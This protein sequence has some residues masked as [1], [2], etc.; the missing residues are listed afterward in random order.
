MRSQIAQGIYSGTL[1]GVTSLAGHLG[2]NHKTV[3]SALEQLEAEGVLLSQGPRRGRLIAPGLKAGPRPMRIVVLT[4]EASDR[5]E[6]YLVRVQ[7]ALIEAGHEVTFARKSITEL[8]MNVVSLARMVKGSDADVWVVFSGSF[9]VLEWFSNRGIPV[10]AIFGRRKSFPIAGMSVN[11]EGAFKE[12]TEGLISRGHRRMVM[13]C[14]SDRRIPKIGTFER[15]FLDTLTSHEIPVGDYNLPDWEESAAGFRELLDSLFLVTPPTVLIFQESR[16]LLPAMQFLNSKGLKV[17]GNVSL[18]CCASSP[19]FLW[20]QP[21][22][23]H[24]DWEFSH[25]IRRVVRWAKKISHGHTDTICSEIPAHIV[26][27]QSIGPVP[28]DIY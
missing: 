19:D 13:I 7:H 20:C 26:D 5:E 24:L 25:L 3:V 12:V 15:G 1:P 4:Y 22:I 10:F 2:V 21:S 6:S 11:S 14:R 8:K 23:A 18:F 17:P 16:Y 28:S 9:P 27:G